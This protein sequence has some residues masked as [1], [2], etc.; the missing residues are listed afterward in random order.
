M[1]FYRGGTPLVLGGALIR[2]AQFGVYEN[3]MSFLKNNSYTKNLN[4]YRVCSLLDYHVIIGGICG[5]IGRGLI[6]GPFEFVKVRRQVYGEWKL[7]DLFHGYGTTLFRNSFL[8]GAFVIYLDISKQLITGGLSP[9]MSGALC[10]TMAWLTIWPLDVVKS[11]LQSGLFK[12]QNATSILL[13]MIKNHPKQLYSGVAPGLIRSA[14]A[15][16][17]SMYMYKYVERNLLNVLNA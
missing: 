2:S 9:F 7:K 4:D 3:T 1:G 6:E 11:K 15:N 10:S 17:S 16:G 13:N 8:F 14:I 5:G 12:N